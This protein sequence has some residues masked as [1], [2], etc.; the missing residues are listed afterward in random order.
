[1]LQCGRWSLGRAFAPIISTGGHCMLFLRND[2]ITMRNLRRPC[3]RPS[4]AKGSHHLTRS[5]C[6]LETV[7]PPTS[8]LPNPSKYVI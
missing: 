8:R 4:P 3:Q 2:Q 6:W 7:H 1:L 5:T